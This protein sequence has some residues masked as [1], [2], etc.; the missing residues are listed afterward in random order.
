MSICEPQGG[1]LRAGRALPT[2]SMARSPGP[3]PVSGLQD[4]GCAPADITEGSRVRPGLT[5]GD[6][7]PFSWFLQAT[8]LLVETQAHRM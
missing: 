6:K 5:L 1:L 2:T 4:G 3:G 8:S 7:M